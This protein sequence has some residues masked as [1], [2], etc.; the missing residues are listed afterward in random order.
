MRSRQRW[1]EMIGGL[2]SGPIQPV[3]YTCNKEINPCRLFMFS[4]C[5]RY[6]HSNAQ[7]PATLDIIRKTAKFLRWYTREWINWRSFGGE[8]KPPLRQ[9]LCEILKMKER[10][11]EEYETYLCGHW[12]IELQILSTT[13][14][15]FT[16]FPGNT[17]RLWSCQ[18]FNYKVL[19]PGRW[20][21]V[22]F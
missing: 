3:V 5:T 8:K 12:L 22:F 14:Q 10:K 11:K 1:R 7:E 16:H 15:K 19:V 6:T 17:K 21:R 4:V 18:H 2:D 9:K 20:F 13:R